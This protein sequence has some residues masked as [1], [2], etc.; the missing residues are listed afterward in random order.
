MRNFLLTIMQYDD[1]E[2]EPCDNDDR[3]WL[4]VCNPARTP[5]MDGTL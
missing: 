1:L 5:Y 4:Q 3:L 2:D